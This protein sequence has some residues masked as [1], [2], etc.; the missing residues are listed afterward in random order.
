[1]EVL[2]FGGNG[3]IGGAIMAALLAAGHAVTAQNRGNVY[4]GVQPDPRVR[5][6]TVCFVGWVDAGFVIH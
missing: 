4:W 5:Q 1:M 6:I 3:F 2:V